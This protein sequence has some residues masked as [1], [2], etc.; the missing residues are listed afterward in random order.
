MLCSQG[1]PYG[2]GDDAGG[3][4]RGVRRRA[5]H[6]PDGVGRERDPENDML[7]CPSRSGTCVVQRKAPREVNF[8]IQYPPA[9]LSGDNVFPSRIRG[10]RSIYILQ[11]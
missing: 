9:F 10:N 1:L 2:V 11:Q 6:V 7:A 5:L 3:E 8:S 4:N